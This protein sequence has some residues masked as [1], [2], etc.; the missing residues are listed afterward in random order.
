MADMK[1]IGG[2]LIVDGKI[3]MRQLELMVLKEKSFI[4]GDVLDSDTLEKELFKN[5][6][7]DAKTALDIIDRVELKMKREL[8]TM[9]AYR[10]LFKEWGELTVEQLQQI[11]DDPESEY[12]KLRRKYHD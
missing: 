2:T 8:A 7:V 4:W 12:N 6:P 5:G 10:K 1:F 3:V 11:E 9:D